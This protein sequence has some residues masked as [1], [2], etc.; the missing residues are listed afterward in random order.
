MKPAHDLTDLRKEGFPSPLHG[1]FA[2]P[3]MI[4]DDGLAEIAEVLLEEGP[5]NPL[6]R[7]PATAF[8]GSPWG[9]PGWLSMAG[10]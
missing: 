4:S 10:R 5:D 1:F 7:D 8:A 6:A 9:D 3:F 2:V